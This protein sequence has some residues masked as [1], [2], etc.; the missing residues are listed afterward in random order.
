MFENKSIGIYLW[1]TVIGQIFE[2]NMRINLLFRI[3]V[4]LMYHIWFC[5]YK[6]FRN[7]GCTR[8]VNT[9]TRQ[10]RRGSETNSTGA[11]QNNYIDDKRIRDFRTMWRQ[12][13]VEQ[14]WQKD[15]D[16]MSSK[17]VCSYLTQGLGEIWVTWFI[18]IIKCFVCC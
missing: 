11:R 2:K 8:N 14:L 15:S 10:V 4:Y 17:S 1:F 7:I 9:N 5:I 12:L 16:S 13:L 18:W 3:F 6:L